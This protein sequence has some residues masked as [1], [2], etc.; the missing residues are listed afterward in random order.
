MF[1]EPASKPLQTF[2]GH[3]DAILRIAY[4]AGQLVT[5]SADKTTRIWDVE[6]GEQDGMPMEDDGWVQGLAITRDGK[7]IVS[8]GLDG[9]LR[10]WDAETHE[11]EEEWSGHENAICDIAMSPCGQLLASCDS[12][13]RVIIREMEEGGEIMRS[14]ETGP[15]YINSICFSPDGQSLASAHDDMM[16]R[17]FNVESGDLILGPIEGHTDYVHAVIWS[18]DGRQLFTASWD[19]TIRSWDSATGEAIG[20]PW[21]GH[22]DH[23]NS[24]SLSPDGKKLASASSD[25]TVRFWATDTGD[26]IGHPL[27]HEDV[28]WTVPFSPTGEFVVCGGSDGKI[29]SWRVPW[30]NASTEKAHFSF[31]DRP[32]VPV[33]RGA[34]NAVHQT[35]AE[36]FGHRSP[37]YLDPPAFTSPSYPSHTTEEAS[38]TQSSA[39]TWK[40][41]RIPRLL[42]R[43]SHGLPRPA[44]TTI[45]Y[46]GYATQLQMI[47]EARA[48]HHS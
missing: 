33:P 6:S 9:A 2:S 19:Q 39:F 14:I 41:W 45:V 11:L 12:K 5:C 23:V 16:V 15:N 37:D 3:E 47:A 46:R 13:G 8:G 25:Q 38:R 30:W 48:N 40:L 43:R 27:Q 31:L 21:T 10:V 28:V 36:F 44:E 32:A 24:I 26:P 35:A 7:R 34:S 4:L 1:I 29:S 42:F 20:Q 17:V 18:L 22:T